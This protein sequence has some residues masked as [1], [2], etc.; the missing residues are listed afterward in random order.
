MSKDRR[1]LLS[2]SG[3]LEKYLWTTFTEHVSDQHVISIIVLINAKFAENVGNV[4]DVM[5]NDEKKFPSFFNRVVDL[6]DSSDFN[7]H[8]LIIAYYKFL[9]N[10]YSS[11]ENPVVRKAGLR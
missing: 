2:M 1:A 10:F 3:Y 9:I 4:F 6:I 7:H 11:L 5:T 8:E